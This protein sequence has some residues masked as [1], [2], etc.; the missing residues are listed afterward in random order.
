M[1]IRILIAIYIMAA[2][3]TFGHAVNNPALSNAA[4]RDGLVIIAIFWPFYWSCELQRP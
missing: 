3:L 4:K 2:I 1:K